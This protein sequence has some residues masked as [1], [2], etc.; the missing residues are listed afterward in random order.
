MCYVVF[1][2]IRDILSGVSTDRPILLELIYSKLVKL[3]FLLQNF[4][5][6]ITSCK[7]IL[8]SNRKLIFKLHSVSQHGKGLDGAE[9]NYQALELTDMTF[10][11]PATLEKIW[12]G[13]IVNSSLASTPDFLTIPSLKQCPMQPATVG[14]TISL[15]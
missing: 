13:A 9:A 4:L 3:L 7:F 12:S 15:L 14:R 5:L 8:K 1:H 10:L 2:S 6:P 11:P